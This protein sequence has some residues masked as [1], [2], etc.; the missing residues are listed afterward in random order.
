MALAIANCRLPIFSRF[1]LLLANRQ[2]KVEIADGF[3]H[4]NLLRRAASLLTKPGVSTG[5]LVRAARAGWKRQDQSSTCL[6]RVAT[7]EIG[8]QFQSYKKKATGNLRRSL[9]KYPNQKAGT[10]GS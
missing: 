9:L 10:E 6:R 4:L 8:R 2:P 1:R 3:D 5:V 7:I